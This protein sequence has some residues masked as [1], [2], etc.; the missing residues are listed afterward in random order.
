M[1]LRN[2]F[3]DVAQDGADITSPTAMPTGGAGIRGWLSAIWTK[4]NGSLAVTGTF[5]QAT[6]P[7]S[8]TVTANVG[9]GTQPVS[10]TVTANV[11]TG[12]LAG[13]TATVVVKAD[14]AGNQANALKTD[15]SAVTQP[16]SGTV[17]VANLPSATHTPVVIYANALTGIT[18]E[19]L[20]TLQINK[21]GTTSSGTAYTVTAGKTFR[22]MSFSHT[23]IV[24]ATTGCAS[25]V[26][27]RSAAT[28]AASSPVSAQSA[29]GTGNTAFAAGMN[30]QTFPEASVEI[31]GGQQVGV[32]H[33]ESSTIAG[34]ATTGA[35][36]AFCIAGYEF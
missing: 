5:W 20:T 11:G 27:L 33:I 13:I 24:P 28:V 15:G 21:G 35:G 23:V 14:T 30:S 6:Q 9:T 22:V 12:S 1:T 8:G 7:V 10:G 34:S 3:A 36:V 31:A 25:R 32:S 4:L 16:V 19:A 18:T 26:F 2:A 17:T 29:V